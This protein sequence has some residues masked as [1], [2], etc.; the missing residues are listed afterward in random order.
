MRN[1]YLP[2]VLT[3]LIA[4]ASSAQAQEPDSKVEKK[5]Q[6]VPTAEPHAP[7]QRP[8]FPEQTRAPQLESDVELEVQKIV[9]GL[10]HPWGMAF[11]PDGRLL[12]TEKSGQLRVVTQQGELSAPVKGVPKVDTRGQGGLLDVNLAPDFETSRMVYLS[13]AEPTKDKKTR[14]AVA[15]GKLS[16]DDKEL[17]KVE[18][19]FRQAPPWD[20][21]FH[22]GSR[23]IW[24]NQGRLYITLGERSKPEPR[25]LA[26]DLST[27]LG[28]VVRLN[29]DGSVPTDNPFVDK[30]DARPEIWSYGHRNIQGAALH[31]GSGR[32]WTI[33]HGP[34]GGDELNMPKAGK[35]YGWPVITYGEDYSGEPIGSGIT[36]NKNMEQPIYYWD[37]VIAPAG[38]IF[39]QGDMFKEW[40]GDIL[41]SSLR[42]GSVVRL[43]V[44]DQRVVGEER[45]LQKVGRVR[46]IAE[47]ANG[48]LWIITDKDNG[49]LLKVSR[50]D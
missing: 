46:D 38:M 39:Y 19:I 47:D 21:T 23:L 13:Y 36:Q 12:V 44:R 15:R 18:V 41:I 11:L 17:K 34:Q 37:P 42:P 6:P 29:A 25:V 48:A 16:K 7:H 32:L 20:S 24:D 27:H 14:T 35:N 4:L 5:A 43:N 40:Q 28:K 3:V 49:E 30:K 31:P 50:A 45:L 22:Y 10:S 33:E 2:V 9:S 26:Q 1:A 8:A